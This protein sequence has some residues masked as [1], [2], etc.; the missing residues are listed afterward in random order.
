M[1]K[2]NKFTE[3]HVMFV[4]SIDNCLFQCEE[5]FQIHHSYFTL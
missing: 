3:I 4:D 1:E 2:I 5:H